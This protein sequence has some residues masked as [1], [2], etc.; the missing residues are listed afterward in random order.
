MIAQSRNAAMGEMISM[1]AH[2]WRQPLTAISMGAN[3]LI[4]DVELEDVNE[5]SLK[6]NLSTIQKQS[7][8]LSKTIDDFKN[9]F[10]PTKN[11]EV[12]II[13]KII[14]DTQSIINISLIHNNIKLTL[15]N[16]NTTPI[17]IYKRELMQV[18]L[19]IINNSKDAFILNNIKTRN[20]NITIEENNE[21]IIININDNAG[22]IEKK[23]INDIFNPYFTTKKK[24]NGTGIGLYMSK[25]IIENHIKGKLL[26]ENIE[27]GVC[28][29]IHLP[30][31]N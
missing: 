6:E 21:Y 24:M 19:N 4:L 13:E 20:I 28:F 9:Y 30:K 2:Q 17:N 10:S 11:K 29:S 23:I 8:H 5:K 1:I 14:H 3:N 15:K 25:I 12:C 26:V 7:E 22:G 27:E 16:N 18:L 31:D